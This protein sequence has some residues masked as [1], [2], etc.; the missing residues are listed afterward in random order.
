M[1][2][3]SF[4]YQYPDLC[5]E[6]DDISDFCLKHPRFCKKDTSISYLQVSIL[7]LPP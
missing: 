7:L 1:P 2:R 3:T 6:P 5:T 4:C